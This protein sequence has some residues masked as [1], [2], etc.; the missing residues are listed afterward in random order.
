M[1]RP[2]SRHS[3][4]GPPRGYNRS[5]DGM[6]SFDDDSPPP[7]REELGNPRVVYPGLMD[8]DLSGED[9]EL[10]H[11]Y[12]GFVAGGSPKPEHLKELVKLVKVNQRHIHLP[13]YCMN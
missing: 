13:A 11:H 7:R 8:P 4:H 5:P 2:I 12:G 10:K 9:V 1:S 6:D 3:V